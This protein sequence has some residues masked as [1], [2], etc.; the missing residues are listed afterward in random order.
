MNYENAT[1]PE[2][3]NSVKLLLI[4]KHKKE[5]DFD[6]FFLELLKGSNPDYCNDPSYAWPIILENKIE[7]T[8]DGGFTNL[9][10]AKHIKHIDEY[11][12]DVVGANTHKNPLRAAMIVYLMMQEQK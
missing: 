1:D 2:I 7:L 11:D 10:E 4:S 12:V 8:F 5:S 6:K 9:W 3:N